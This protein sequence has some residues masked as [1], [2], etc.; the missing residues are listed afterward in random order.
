MVNVRSKQPARIARAD[1]DV[2]DPFLFQPLL[3]RADGDVRAVGLRVVA[4]LQLQAVS[5]GAVSLQHQRG[6]TAIGIEQVVAVNVIENVIPVGVLEAAEPERLIKT[7]VARDAEVR[8]ENDADPTP[9]LV[10]PS[11]V[12]FGPDETQQ[13]RAVVFECP[14]VRSQGKSQSDEATDEVCQSRAS[15]G[16]RGNPADVQFACEL[17]DWRGI[18]E[19]GIQSEVE[20]SD[21]TYA[22]SHSAGQVP[23][24]IA[25][26]AGDINRGVPAGVAEGDKHKRYG[27]A[28]QG[29]VA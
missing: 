7:A 23:F 16:L 19:D 22:D 5:V 10:D 9:D 2:V 26:F 24:R 13:A 28:R 6:E 17:L 21:Y 29:E 8:T 4:P 11:G 12:A 25:D 14:G 18:D 27:E 15:K 3:Q 20:Q 1:D